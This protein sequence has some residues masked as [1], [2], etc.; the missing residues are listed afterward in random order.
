MTRKKIFIYGIDS[1]YLIFPVF[2]YLLKNGYKVIFI[3]NITKN[4]LKKDIILTSSSSKQYE[5]FKEI[6]TYNVYEMLDNKILFY[7]FIKNI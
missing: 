7:E 5:I 6:Y 4:N 2:T 3:N 1:K